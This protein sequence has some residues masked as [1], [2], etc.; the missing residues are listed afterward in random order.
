MSENRRPVDA[1]RVGAIKGSIW[2]NEGVNG[3]WYSVSLNGSTGKTANGNRAQAS[4]KM[5][6]L[7]LQRLSITHTLNSSISKAKANGH[8]ESSATLPEV[9]M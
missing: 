8:R 7:L 5:T 4:E 6:C 3:L 9:H 1:I 2:K